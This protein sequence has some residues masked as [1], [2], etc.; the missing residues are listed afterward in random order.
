[1]LQVGDLVTVSFE[2]TAPVTA[3]SL[4]ETPAPPRTTT[5]AAA[6]REG[7]EIEAGAMKAETTSGIAA[8]KPATRPGAA[9]VANRSESDSLGIG[10][11]GSGERLQRQSCTG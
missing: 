6:P 8:R 3:V 2:L 5:L 4:Q 9:V 10:P 7:A 11:L 1:M